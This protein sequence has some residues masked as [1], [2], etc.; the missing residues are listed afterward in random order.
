MDDRD[1]LYRD[2][3]YT[4]DGEVKISTKY[5]VK[6]GIKGVLSS[7]VVVALIALVVWVLLLVVKP[8]AY[9]MDGTQIN[10]NKDLSSV[11]PN[12]VILVKDN[13][14]EDSIGKQYVVESQVLKLPGSYVNNETGDMIQLDQNQYLLTFEGQTGIVEKE[15]IIGVKK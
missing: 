3:G 10:Y 5:K 7:L 1:Y 14:V 4:K 6:R 12:S 15:N 2:T 8:K 11:G 9:T 13:R